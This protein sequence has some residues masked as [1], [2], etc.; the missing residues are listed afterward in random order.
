MR[1]SIALI[2]TL[3]RLV[4]APLL[5]PVLCAYGIPMRSY[6]INSLLA[7][8]FLVLSSTDFLDGYLARLYKQETEL[9][10]LLDPIADKFLMYSILV[11]LV[12]MHKLHFVWALLFIGREFFV[13]GLREIALSHKSKLAVIP[14]A[15]FKTVA[16]VGAFAFVLFNPYQ[17][18]HN[19]FWYNMLEFLLLSCALVLSLSSAYYYSKICLAS[20]RISHDLS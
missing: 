20:V 18:H 3:I 14:S 17:D 11:T 2:L 15:K 19:A 9:G 4:S 8:V 12:Y 5:L 13:M 1:W 16:Q 10:R 6:T 7:G